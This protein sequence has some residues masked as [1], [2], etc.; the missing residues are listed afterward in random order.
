MVHVRRRSVV[1]LKM[2]LFSKWMKLFV[3]MCYNHGWREWAEFLQHRPH[4][5]HR[6]RSHL[7]PARP[8]PLYHGPGSRGSLL[9]VHTNIPTSLKSIQHQ[10]S[11]ITPRRMFKIK[12]QWKKKVFFSCSK[13]LRNFINLPEEKLDWGA[14][15][16]QARWKWDIN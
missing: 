16:V 1:S 7:R 5:L 9:Q 12:F 4:R 11:L 15:Q 8:V 2:R 3:K 10:Y 6:L 13:C 14:H